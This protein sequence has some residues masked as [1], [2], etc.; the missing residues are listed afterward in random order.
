MLCVLNGGVVYADVP[1]EL[2]HIKP[3]VDQDPH[4]NVNTLEDEE[5]NMKIEGVFVLSVYRLEIALEI[6]S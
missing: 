3:C 2:Q 6:E 4:V 1:F 5:G